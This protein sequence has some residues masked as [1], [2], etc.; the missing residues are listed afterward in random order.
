MVANVLLLLIVVAQA[1]SIRNVFLWVC[2]VFV[3]E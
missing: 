3:S 1:L 2:L